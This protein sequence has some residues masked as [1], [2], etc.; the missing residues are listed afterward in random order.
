MALPLHKHSTPEKI[1]K[2]HQE[3]GR[4]LASLVL[5]LPSLACR[6]ER[7]QI[8]TYTMMQDA[9]ILQEIFFS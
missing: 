7:P 2:D 6:L 4:P 5:H 3:D 9:E 1:P 8:K